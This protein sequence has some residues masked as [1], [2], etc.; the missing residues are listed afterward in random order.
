MVEMNNYLIINTEDP[1][2]IHI[3]IINIRENGIL[4][5]KV[6]DMEFYNNRIREVAKDIYEIYKEH[7]IHLQHMIHDKT[8]TAW[9]IRNILSD[10]VYDY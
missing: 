6:F 9:G 2:K 3:M 8:R 5:N 10:L 4:V 7:N 1:L